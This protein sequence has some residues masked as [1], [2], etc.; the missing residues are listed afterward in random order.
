MNLNNLKTGKRL[1]LGFG[2][3]A[4]LMLILVVIAWWQMGAMNTDMDSSLRE[5]DKMIKIRDVATSLDNLYLEMWG[6]VTSSDASAKKARQSSVEAKRAEYLKSMGE[7][8]TSETTEEG[9]KL[10]SA[11]EAVVGRDSRPQSEH[12]GYGT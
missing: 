12:H 7:L 6:L 9:K 3:M 2:I 11:L 8:K 5:A 4:A 1:T 10:L